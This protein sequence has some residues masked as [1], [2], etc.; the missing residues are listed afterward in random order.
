MPAGSGGIGMALQQCSAAWTT[1]PNTAFGTNGQRSWNGRCW[2]LG[3]YGYTLGNLVVPPNSAYP[4]CEFWST[5]AD[6]DAGGIVGLTS[7][8]SG[9]ANVGMA[10]GSVRFLKST[11]SY[12][13][14]WALGSRSQGETLSADSY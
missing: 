9:G 6:W 3:L 12:P 10:D 5:N 11:V 13:T 4:Y 8:H 14:L 1:S 7:F 2:Q